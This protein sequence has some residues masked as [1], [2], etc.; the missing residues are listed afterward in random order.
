MR[1]YE[2]AKDLTIDFLEKWLVKYKLKN[3]NEYR[4]NPDLLGQEVTLDQKI[5]RVKEIA[6]HL[7]NNNK[8]KSHGRPINITALNEL[9]LQI[10][11]YSN[12][13]GRGCLIRDY[14]EL[15]AEYV[16]NQRL[17]HFVHTR[18]FI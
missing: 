5:E 14:Y 8:W 10:D 17:T 13:P 12:E 18:K 3:W 6:V 16:M 15:M 11:D 1:C 7:S 9:K 4:T 2:Q